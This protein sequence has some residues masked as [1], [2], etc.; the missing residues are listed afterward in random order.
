[1]LWD[2]IITAG[3]EI[4]NKVIPDPAQKAEAQLKLLQLQQAGEFK[5]LEIDLQLAQGQV[6][7]NKIEAESDDLFKSG[8]RPMVGWT[9]ALGF[10]AK[11]MGG[12]LLFVISQYFGHPIE[13]P[14]IDTMELMPLLFGMLGLGAYR[15][16]EKVKLK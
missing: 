15:T 14:E 16:Y 3:L 9:C 6:D 8:W 12:P 11:Y 10:F 1:M 13:L 5:Q 7:I 4:I 2:G